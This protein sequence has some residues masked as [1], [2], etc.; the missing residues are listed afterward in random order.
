MRRMGLVGEGSNA[1][2]TYLSATSRLLEDPVSNIYVGNSAA[3]KSYTMLAAMRLIPDEE[4]IVRQRFSAQAIMYTPLE[5]EHKVV[6]ILERT[7]AEAGAYNIRTIQSEKDVVIEVTHRDTSGN[8]GTAEFRKKG[9]TAFITSTVNPDIDA[10]DLSRA[11]VLHPDESEAQT[12]AILDSQLEEYDFPSA[13]LELWHDAQRCLAR[14][15]V[16][17]P[18]R[19]G[20]AILHF[21][22]ARARPLPPRLRRDWRHIMALIQA[23]ALLHQYQRPPS[24]TG[25]ILP[26]LRDYYIAR[27]IA[28][29]VFDQSVLRAADPKVRELA[30]AVRLLYSQ[31]GSSIKADVIT[32]HLRWGKT[33]V[34]GHLRAAQEAGLVQEDPTAHYAYMPTLSPKAGHLGIVSD[35]GLLP[36]VDEIITFDPELGEGFAVIDPLTGEEMEDLPDEGK[37]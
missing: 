12:E 31:A 34:Y 27:V 5:F 7:G 30:G 26:D 17:V 28:R 21:M 9:P 10:Q 15:P 4:K 13:E 25:K 18:G 11:F 32:S 19:L 33:T 36:T 14:V 24:E 3:G 16:A 37:K 23:S 22:K 1:L 20:K 8:F 2:T 35:A 29:E 6:V